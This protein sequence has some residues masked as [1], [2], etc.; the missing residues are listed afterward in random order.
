MKGEGEEEEGG[1]Y[2]PASF[3]KPL[4][5]HCPPVLVR[6]LVGGGRL[7]RE[8]S[9]EPTLA[10]PPLPRLPLLAPVHRP[11]PLRARLP[12][13]LVYPSPSR[14]RPIARSP[15]SPSLSS[16]PFAPSPSPPLVYILKVTGKPFHGVHS[17]EIAM[18]CGW[19]RSSDGAYVIQR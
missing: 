18:F 9:T 1:E 16:S 2:S 6:W 13:D 7:P 11:L 17:M 19:H 14:H 10:S 12:S 3:G 15:L 5:T 4:L 8:V